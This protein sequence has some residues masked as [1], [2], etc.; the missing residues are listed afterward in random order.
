MYSSSE[1]EILFFVTSITA[2]LSLLGCLFIILVYLLF[3]ELRVFAFKLVVHMT[4]GDFLRSLGFLLQ[5]HYLCPVQAMLI[6]AGSLASILWNGVIARTL[7]LSV[8]LELRDM[9]EM[10]ARYTYGVYGVVAVLTALPWTTMDYG[11]AEGWCWINTTSSNYTSGTV[12]RVVCF[13]LPLL[14]VVL[15]NLFSYISVIR[16]LRKNFQNTSGDI[17]ALIQ[18]L[19]FYPIILIVC[20]TCTASKRLYDAVA[21]DADDFVWAVL[22]AMMLGSIGLVDALVYGFTQSVRQAIVQKLCP[23]RDRSSS[24]SSLSDISLM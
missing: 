20:Y 9:E 5:S 19:R 6:Q 16:A 10:E 8:V 15:N 12:W 14:L 3:K 21:S 7:Y 24:E 11:D 23:G 18:K 2:G 22:V 17:P 13:F 1:R 4:I